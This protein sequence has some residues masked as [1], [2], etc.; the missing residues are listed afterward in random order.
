MKVWKNK[1]STN[2]SRLTNIHFVRGNEFPKDFGVWIESSE[3]ELES[4]RH[5]TKLY[6]QGG[7][8]YF[9]KL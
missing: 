4:A 6:S 3:E 5:N 9:G 2:D 1:I 7:I 8:E